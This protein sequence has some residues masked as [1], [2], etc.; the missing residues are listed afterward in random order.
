MSSPSSFPV[1]GLLRQNPWG[2]LDNSLAAVAFFR[3]VHCPWGHTLQDVEAYE[4]DPAAF[5]KKYAKH[6]PR[7]PTGSLL[8]LAEAKKDEA[9]LVRLTS[10]TR[11]GGFH[12]F[13]L[14]RRALRSCGH[15][16]TR[17]DCT[18]CSE[19]IVRV[20]NRYEVTKDQLHRHMLD[21]CIAEHFNTL[22]RDVEIVG[23]VRL[24]GDDAAAVRHYVCACQASLK[25]TGIDVPAALIVE[26][27]YVL[28]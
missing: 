16:M 17:P 4:A 7:F 8:L 26:E 20:Y 23:R 24:T 21:G 1:S 5:N 19:S 25:T 9:L 27:P 15:P 11:T 18:D 2:K 22:F 14:V 12:Y 28:L 6:F 10:E 13:I 3:K